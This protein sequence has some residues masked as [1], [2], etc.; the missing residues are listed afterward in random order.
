MH[1]TLL[2]GSALALSAVVSAQTFVIAPD[3]AGLTQ[4]SSSTLA[5]RD[6]TTGF[7]SQFIYD[8]S[9]F[10]NL[11]VTGPCVINRMRFRAAN[12]STSIG[13]SY[14]GDGVTTGV[15][16]DIGTSTTDYLTPS[17]TFATNRG[18]MQN[19]LTF[20]TVTCAAGAGL[21]PNN[22]VIDITIPGGF[23]Y[24]PT[25]GSD[26]LIDV[27][28]PDFIGTI[29]T[30]STGI[31]LAASRCNRVA[32]VPSTA[33]TGT[34]SAGFCP[35][36]IF[37]ITG[38]GGIADNGGGFP[39][40][41]QATSAAYG[42]GCPFASRSFAELFPIATPA[43]DL[44]T[45]VAMTPDVGGAPTRYLVSSGAAGF[46]THTG[47]VLLSNAAVPAALGDDTMSQACNLG[48]SF[49]FVGGS[50]SV[51][52]ANTNGYIVLGP[53]TVTGGDFSPTLAELITGTSHSGLPR[54]FPCW[55]DLHAG[56]NTTTNPAAGLYFDVDT[57]N[58]KAYLTWDDVGELSTSTAGAKS[59]NMQVEL[60]ATGAVEIRYGAMSVFGSTTQSKIVGFTPG[61]TS[62][63]PFSTDLST[64]MPFL[65]SPVDVVGPPLVL[66]VTPP[67]IG[68]TATFTTTNV[69]A[70]GAVLNWISATQVNPGI[71]LGILGMPGCSAYMDPGAT[72]I[73]SLVFGVGT[74][75]F[76]VTVP[77]DLNL[78]G[79]NAYSQSAALNPGLNAFGAETSNGVAL[80]VGNV[81]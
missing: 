7:R 26:L 60:S 2:A 44:G 74:V 4:P 20:A 75:A 37:D 10:T 16:L 24:D 5:W 72:I 42:V 31:S 55:Y 35:V 59:F 14:P 69:P 53:T 48:F 9:H 12:A 3:N 73:E 17:T 50:T 76:A 27:T 46:F 49:P 81:Q 32:N 65:S 79:L 15:T 38:P 21:T 29:P 34:T 78:V 1:K 64:S 19:V 22:Y 51:V 40:F 56:R 52:H 30:M 63:T 71:D 25:G 77:Y 45:G 33:L 13:G 54:L 36:V 8:T 62:V 41:N 6:S 68:D 43:L 28:G 39:A 70:P 18:T 23:A 57:V 58:Q 67:R 61:S 80:H 11:G 47:P 66:A